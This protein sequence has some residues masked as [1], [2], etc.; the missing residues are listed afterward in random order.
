MSS[1]LD[2]HQASNSDILLPNGV[3]RIPNDV[4]LPTTGL[5]GV[6]GQH[7]NSRSVSIH[8][9]PVSERRHLHHTQHVCTYQLLQSYQR[10]T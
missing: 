9:Y 10:A 4:M 8:E 7:I 6:N 3:P 5:S 1:A 2:V